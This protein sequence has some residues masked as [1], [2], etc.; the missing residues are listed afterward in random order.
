[1]RDFAEGKIST[2]NFWDIYR[3]NDTIRQLL[4]KDK[5]RAGAEFITAPKRESFMPINADTALTEIDINRLDHRVALYMIVK[6]YFWYRVHLNFYN[7]DEIYQKQ[8][9]ELIPHWVGNIDSDF[10]LQHIDCTSQNVL[11]NSKIE[12]YKTKIKNLFRCDSK[13]PKWVQEAEWP[14]VDGTPYAF[15]YQQTTK[16]GLEQ[17]IFYAPNDKSKTIIVEQCE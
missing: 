17:Y 10:I 11:D 9:D 5:F 12:D 3:Q 4:I 15:D 2:Q 14:I 13:P 1:M 6:R 8:L 7:E 16:D